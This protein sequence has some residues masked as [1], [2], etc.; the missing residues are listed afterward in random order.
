MNLGHHLKIVTR[1]TN[2]PHGAINVADYIGYLT[3]LSCDP[4]SGEKSRW[5]SKPCRLRARKQTTNSADFRLHKQLV[6]SQ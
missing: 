5:P 2:D 6:D 1:P 3:L 4:Q